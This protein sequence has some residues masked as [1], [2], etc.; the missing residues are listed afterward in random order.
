MNI[1]AAIIDQR[2]NSVCD[3]IRDRAKDE[4]KIVDE[5]KLRSL[6]FV[7][8]SVKTMLDLS[9][10]EAFD[11]LVE[12][13]QDF[14]VDAIHFS[15]E[16]DG[17]FIVSLFQGKYSRKLEG[18]SNFPENGIKALI[19]AI[20]HLFDPSSRL[21]NLNQRLSARVE[22]IRSMI[23]E[24]TIP[25]VRAL[26]CNNGL[27][28]NEAAEQTIS[29]EGFGNQVTWEHINHD[30]LVMI[31]Q[32]A[33]PVNDA[34]QLTGAAIIEDLNFSRVLVARIAAAE[35]AALIQRHGERLLERNIRRY[36]GLQGNR[37]NEAMRDTL[38]GEESSNF[39]FYNNGITL[40][41]DKF[42]YNALQ[43]RDY[44]V[45]V[46]NL[47]IINGGQTCITIFKTLQ[48][49]SESQV[50]MNAYLLV[51]LYQLPSDNEDLVKSI[52]FA[53]NS[54]NPVDLRDLRAN[55]DRQ[56]RLE[57]DI[58]QLGFTYRRKRTDSYLK[59]KDI[60]SGVAAEAI[61]S[62]WR[63]RPHQAKFLTREHFGKLY[64]IIFSNDLNGT[65]V[66]ISTLIYRHAENKRKRP[67]EGTPQFI[68]YASCFISM[69]M[70]KYLLKDLGC[71]ITGLTHQNYET[72]R[73]LIELKGDEYF[74][75]SVHDVKQ[76]L[77]ML[78]RE[79][80]ISLQQLSATFRRSDLIE[81]LDNL[82]R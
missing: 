6:A 38:R 49:M 8:L 13:G 81:I 3:E 74:N 21:E 39:Y 79:S 69:Q 7:H 77:G 60:T 75:Q 72:A 47:Q 48:E 5:E 26:A 53:T 73:Q 50:P 55:D 61:L 52:T 80:D 19:N 40:T 46:E 82:D 31:F 29:Q 67:P 64:D 62:V 32:R 54:Q 57:T 2:L 51:R 10:D 1:N 56:C 9:D 24:G 28:W 65:Q 63:K 11:C 70:G 36:L 12:G 14:G 45:R 58:S 15:E 76:A 23:R 20:R 59:P 25:Q 66:I 68:R 37:V 34:L 22:E 43:N 44:Q 35:V 30:R 16:R 78:Y 27:K 18:A 4:L 33:K 71:D 17:E 41:C 42:T